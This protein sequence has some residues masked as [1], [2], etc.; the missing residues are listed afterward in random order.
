[1]Q[2]TND[3][4]HLKNMEGYECFDIEWV[5]KAMGNQPAGNASLSQL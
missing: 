2:E 3:Y 5:S 4:S 1:M